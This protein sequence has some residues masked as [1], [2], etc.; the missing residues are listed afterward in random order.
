MYFYR[1]SCLVILLTLNACVHKQRII[2]DT[3]NINMDQY[4]T[5]LKECQQYAQQV[6]TGKDITKGVVGGALIG[7]L[8]GA[9]VG[10]SDTAKKA[11]GA[12][13]V[14]RGAK[15]GSKATAEKS[16]VVKNCLR[17]RGY[18]VLN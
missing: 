16:K 17:G 15:K 3:K 13:A 4:Q 14:S 11:A 18:Q 10:N 1:L 8:I 2:V 12:G 7:G 6:H 5:D 9:A